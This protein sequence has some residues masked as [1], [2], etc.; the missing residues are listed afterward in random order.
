MFQV[1]WQGIIDYGRLKLDQILLK[2][3]GNP[4]ECEK[5]KSNFVMRRYGNGVFANL[6]DDQPKWMPKELGEGFIVQEH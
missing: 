2:S 3:K 6:K 5:L 1:V 4:R